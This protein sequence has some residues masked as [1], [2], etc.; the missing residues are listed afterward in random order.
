MYTPPNID[1]HTKIVDNNIYKCLQFIDK[2]IYIYIYILGG[3]L[4]RYAYVSLPRK[5]G[6]IARE[7]GTIKV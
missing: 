3:M 5:L 2:Y 4:R 7:L 1:I 6:F